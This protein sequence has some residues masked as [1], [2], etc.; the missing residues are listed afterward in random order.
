MKVASP[1]HSLMFRGKTH[2]ALNLLA[3]CGKGGVLHLDQPANTDD[4]DSVSVREVLVS[5]HPTANPHLPNQPNPPYG[6]HLLRF[7]PSFLIRSIDARLIRSTALKTSGAAGPSG[8]DAHAWRRL[9]TAF[10]SA[11]TSLCQS[12]AEIA[13][14]LCT[15]FVDPQGLAPLLVSRLIALDKCPG[16]RPI[17]IGDTARR[18]ITKAVLVIARG[19][20]QDAAGSVQLCAGQASGCETAIHSVRS[21]FQDDDA[22]AT[23]LVDASNTFNSINRMSALL[24]IKHLCPSIATI[25][26]N[27]YRDPTDLFIDGDVIHSCEGTTQ[28]MW[29]AHVR[30]CNV[31]CPRT[32]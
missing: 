17:G 25:L 31:E 18:I 10:K 19:D 30:S 6:A 23:L 26:I 1:A 3:N 32:L 13:K 7:T 29:N 12:L 21:G 14:R 5:K 24:N 28:G 2:A 20:I 11:S 27:C 16:V 4:P 15:S 8:L 22:E 9:C